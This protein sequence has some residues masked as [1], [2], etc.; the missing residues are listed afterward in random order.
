[1]HEVGHVVLG[2]AERQQA[3]RRR[4]ALFDLLGAVGHLDGGLLH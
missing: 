2:V 4:D 3:L 1:V